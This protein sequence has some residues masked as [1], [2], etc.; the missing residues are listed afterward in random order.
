MHLDAF[1]Q[2]DNVGVL[3]LPTDVGLTFQLK[4]VPLRELL[5]VDH[6]RRKFLAG[7]FLEGFYG[8]LSKDL[9]PKHKMQFCLKL[10]GHHD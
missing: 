7:A 5:G 3:Q 10:K 4:E 9:N 1:M 8:D 2:L 6:L